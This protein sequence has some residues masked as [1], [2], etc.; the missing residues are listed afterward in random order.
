M[1]TS[2]LKNYQTG[3]D[4]NRIKLCYKSNEENLWMNIKALGIDK[5]AWQTHDLF[6][7]FM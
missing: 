1:K 6:F 3:K 5:I 4:N 7:F 2:N